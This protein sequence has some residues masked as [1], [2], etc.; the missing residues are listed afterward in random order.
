MNS[1]NNGPGTDLSGKNRGSAWFDQVKG[2]LCVELSQALG[3]SVTDI[4]SDYLPAPHQ[5]PK[6]K[7]LNGVNMAAVY[8]F[9]LSP[10]YGQTCPAGPLRVLKVGSVGP[11]T[12]ARF[13]YQHY[14]GGAD[15][16][17]VGSLLDNPFLWGYLGITGSPTL[18]DLGA[19]LL[20]NTCRYH[21]F[22][23]PAY[24]PRRSKIEVYIRGR[25]GPIFEGG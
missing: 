3:T 17:L 16:T 9:A 4:Q 13:T 8:V 20:A 7:Q 2:D 10:N 5:N 22:L 23:P 18:K 14:N 25:L 19:W 15:S 11:G 12:P 21:L 6:L 24:E 1:A